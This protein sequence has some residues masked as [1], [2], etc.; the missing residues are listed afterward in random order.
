MASVLKFYLKNS[1][2]SDSIVRTSE[3]IVQVAFY[4][5]ISPLLYVVMESRMP[6]QLCNKY[7]IYQLKDNI[8][9]SFLWW[10]SRGTW[11]G[12]INFCFDTHHFIPLPRKER[13]TFASRAMVFVLVAEAGP[14]QFLSLSRSD[15]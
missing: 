13:C 1:S 10:I 5:C 4:F 3:T 7:F 11:S 9:S 2:K 12:H 14:L 15:T 6:Y 8:A